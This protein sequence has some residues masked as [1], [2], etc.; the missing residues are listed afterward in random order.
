LKVSSF[1][2]ATLS[3]NSLFLT[4]SYPF[5]NP[6]IA[7]EPLS[8]SHSP[9]S[10]AFSFTNVPIFDTAVP[11]P[12][13]ADSI[14]LFNPSIKA[15]PF[16]FS[17]SPASLSAPTTLSFTFPANSVIL[18]Q[19]FQIKNPPIIAPTT[20][21]PTGLNKAPAT[22]E[23]AEATAGAN[24]PVIHVP[25]EVTIEDAAGR[26]LGMIDVENQPP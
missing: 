9:A 19:F 14:P 7:S 23:K 4:D 5:F 1:S 20:I 22:A 6:V 26:I 2:V 17:H 16:S 21:K 18:S 12:S 15:E 10:P 11:S 24:V 8:L 13:F 3:K 25:T